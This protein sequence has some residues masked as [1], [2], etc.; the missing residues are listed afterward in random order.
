[1]VKGGLLYR[2]DSL[3]EKRE[4]KSGDKK[5]ESGKRKFFFVF[6]QKRKCVFC[7]R[8]VLENVCD[9]KRK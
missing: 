2:G 7:T 1:M 3:G 9:L 8:A 6:P 5:E 4:R